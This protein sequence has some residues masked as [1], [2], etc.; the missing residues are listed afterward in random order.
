M[1]PLYLF[2]A[3]SSSLMNRIAKGKSG[4][5]ELLK[6]LEKSAE[7]YGLSFEGLTDEFITVQDFDK[8]IKN[9][10]QNVLKIWV[11][12]GGSMVCTVGNWLVDEDF[13]WKTSKGKSRDNNRLIGDKDIVNAWI[14][15][16]DSYI[17]K[18]MP[19]VYTIALDTLKSLAQNQNPTTIVNASS[20]KV[21]TI[22]TA[23]SK[24]EAGPDQQDT[25][26][27]L[28]SPKT[29]VSSFK[30]AKPLTEVNPFQNNS[31]KSIFDANKEFWLNLQGNLLSMGGSLERLPNDA[32]FSDWGN[33][34]YYASKVKSQKNIKDPK[35]LLVWIMSEAIGDSDYSSSEKIPKVV[36]VT[37]G[38]YAVD[39]SLKSI[40]SY[41]SGKVTLGKKE[42]VKLTANGKSVTADICYAIKLF[43]IAGMNSDL[44]DMVRS[45]SKDFKDKKDP[46]KWAAI[47]AFRSNDNNDIQKDPAKLSKFLSEQE[48]FRKEHDKLAE[49][50]NKL[51]DSFI[52]NIRKDKND[53]GEQIQKWKTGTYSSALVS[54]LKKKNV[55]GKNIKIEK[56]FEDSGAILQMHVNGWFIDKAKINH[57]DKPLGVHINKSVPISTMVFQ[58][59]M[60][61][62]KIIDWFYDGSGEL[63]RN[64]KKSIVPRF[65]AYYDLV[66]TETGTTA[67]SKVPIH[68]PMEFMTTK[69]LRITLID[70]QWKAYGTY[71]GTLLGYDYIVDYINK[72]PSGT[73]MS[74]NW[75]Y[76]DY[77]YL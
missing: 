14:E 23:S 45:E 38:D 8:A 34:T 35:W 59:K 63:D 22:K 50:I 26:V 56:E 47:T 31:I 33:D 7:K 75:A 77:K 4:N 39:T 71:M 49:P 44:L 6:K 36:M 48:K 10:A 28:V 52:Q 17:R 57:Y 69:N 12:I 27:K 43:T 76:E 40:G 20:G 19:I 25:L 21:D 29:S 16:G 53:K 46:E 74:T 11:T 9:K 68:L 61:K 24:T 58:E 2:E 1:R 42:F 60:R 51:V 67:Y 32:G 55:F 72:N 5:D 3:H 30:L 66:D 18:L 65:I 37:K 73:I 62:E 70:S 15:N 64:A 13:N 41:K 54:E